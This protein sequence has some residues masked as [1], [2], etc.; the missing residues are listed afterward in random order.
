MAISI[1]NQPPNLVLRSR[2]INLLLTPA[3]SPIVNLK[4]SFSF[5][6][7]VPNSFLWEKRKFFKSLGSN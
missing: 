1:P 7:K 2:Y 5:L 3:A 4:S 6:K